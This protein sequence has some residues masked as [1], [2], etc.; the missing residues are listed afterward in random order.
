MMTIRPILL[1]VFLASGLAAAAE[2]ATVTATEGRIEGVVRDLAGAPVAAC[3]LIV[4]AA[5]DSGVFVS[6]PTDDQGHYALT[7]PRGARY[8]LLAVVAPGGRRIELAEQQPF[9]VGPT[10]VTRDVTIPLSVAADPR[11]ALDPERKIDRFFLGFIEDPVLA[12]DGHYEAQLEIEDFQGRDLSVVRGIAAQHFTSVP[13]TEV[14]ARVGY[15]RLNIDDFSDEAGVTDLEMWGKFQLYPESSPRTEFA[16]G[17]IAT[18]PVGDADEGLGRD[19]LQAKL[20]AGV[21]YAWRK[22]LL[23]AHAGMATSEDGEA[24]GFALDGQ[25]APAIGAGLLIPLAP[26]ASAVFEANYEGERF[27]GTR[28]DANL[29]A[30]ANW[31]IKGHGTVR[32]AATAGLG[33]TSELASITA[34]YVFGH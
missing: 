31:R 28:A 20:F 34:G 17:A 33:E 25:V 6:P 29:L 27:D 1:S 21:T 30:G 7:V 14:G 13:R 2:T 26:S 10:L 16:I 18:L 8:L 12:R 5:E 22:M 11:G 4:R 19:A 3:R 15:A 32:L 9:I 23:L 24:F